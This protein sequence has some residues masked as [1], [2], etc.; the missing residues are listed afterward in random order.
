MDVFKHPV[1]GE[2]IKSS[3]VVDFMASAFLGP[4]YWA[5]VGLWELLVAWLVIIMIAWA[6]VTTVAQL[7]R[8]SLAEVAR[9]AAFEQLRRR[10]AE[11]L[12]EMYVPS[13]P[14]SRREPLMVTLSKVGALAWLA[15]A[16]ICV[17]V[18]KTVLIRRGWR[19]LDEQPADA[20]QAQ[21]E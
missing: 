8:P 17:P 13:E 10:A 19:L 16:L 18:R 5:L 7:N 15:G 4:I 14:T 12:G 11:S 20:S 9:E 6:T 21:P 3:A 1:S 2:T